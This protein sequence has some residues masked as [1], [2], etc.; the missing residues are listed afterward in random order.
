MKP[1]VIAGIVIAGLGAFALVKGLTYRSQ[2][3][4]LKVGDLQVTA[5]EHRLVPPWVGGVALVG[6][7]VLIGAGVRG[8]RGA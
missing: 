3:N 5:E 2:S 1:L 8:R 6:G 7:L 4:V